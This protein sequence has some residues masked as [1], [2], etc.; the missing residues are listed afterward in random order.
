MKVA[1]GERGHYVSMWHCCGDMSVLNSRRHSLVT[2][3]ARHVHHAGR[4]A[5][6]RYLFEGPARRWTKGEEPRR[7][8]ERPRDDDLPSCLV[9]VILA[10]DA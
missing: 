2:Y 3:H 4:D 1:E 8:N 5:S 9:A 10:C 7:Q 6:E